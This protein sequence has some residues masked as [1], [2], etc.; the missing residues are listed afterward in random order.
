M[1][2]SNS[3]KQMGAS[4]L[5]ARRAA[6]SAT[7]ETV[8]RQ[9]RVHI[10]GILHQPVLWI[11]LAGSI[12]MAVA[13]F[14][15]WVRISRSEQI[16][17]FATQVLQRV[18]SSEKINVPP[19][20]SLPAVS[21]AA[22]EVDEFVSTLQKVAGRVGYPI[23]DVPRVPPQLTS[24]W[25]ALLLIAVLAGLAVFLPW[26]SVRL[27]VRVGLLTIGF[28]ILYGGVTALKTEMKKDG[29]QK[30]AGAVKWLSSEKAARLS[31]LWGGSENASALQIPRNVK[32]RPSIGPTLFAVGSLLVI[33]GSS[34]ELVRERKTPSETQ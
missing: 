9:F 8:M 6:S 5:A 4:V 7:D 32:V 30:I 34:Y 24:A 17:R 19:S 22:D 12:L 13:V 26:A 23:E 14:L 16:G 10:S 33:G 3:F 2:S 11:A 29:A 20:M 1:Q 18:G 27:A 31:R 15:P 28:L 21:S 25:I